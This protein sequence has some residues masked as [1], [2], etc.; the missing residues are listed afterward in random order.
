MS[1]SKSV[2]RSVKKT[3]NKKGKRNRNP[4]GGQYD[5]NKSS[6]NKY[7]SDSFREYE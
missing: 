4:K 3:L 2:Q 7:K 1:Y 6:K 5:R